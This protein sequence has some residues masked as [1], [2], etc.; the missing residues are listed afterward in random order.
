MIL[1]GAIRKNERMITD[2][3]VSTPS[4]GIC[5]FETRMRTVALVKSMELSIMI[6]VTGGR[7]FIGSFL[8]SD[9]I[10]KGYDP[11]SIRILS[12]LTE[13]EED[14]PRGVDFCK[15]DVTIL[16]DVVKAFKDV[17]AVFHLAAI[18][19]IPV[20][21]ENP[22][23]V[24]NVNVTGT[25]NVLEAA[26][27]S[28]AKR[29]IFTSASSVYGQPK[30][31]PIDED[32]PTEPQNP[33]GASK[34]AA[35]RYCLSY[36]HT[37]GLEALCLR[38]AN[39]YGRKMTSPNVIQ[40]FTDNAL[41]GRPLVIYGSG[42][43]KKQFTHVSDA[44]QASILTLETSIKKGVYNVVG[45]YDSIVS[46]EDLARIIQAEVAPVPIQYQERR[47]GDVEAADLVI[48]IEKATK[49]LGYSPKVGLREGLS[50]F[51]NWRRTLFE[52]SS[53]R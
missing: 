28:G 51:I 15:G 16:D 26:R 3:I 52:G 14:I 49:E 6:L 9:L 42:K 22:E 19:E 5:S 32:H 33:Y 35:E 12:N 1:K 46:I 48:S 20:S 10:K 21:V 27:K 17:T 40:I 50:D 11:S 13:E 47:S 53:V 8:I 36:Y 2:V 34:L 23:L 24:Y 30:Y 18:K 44:V 39:V 37:Y 25:I 31:V 38:Y 4:Q 41:K 43:Q 29:I 45:G 7:G